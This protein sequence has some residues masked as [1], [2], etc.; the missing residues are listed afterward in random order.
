MKK[1][2]PIIRRTALSDGNFLTSLV[3]SSKPGAKKLEFPYDIPEIKVAPVISPE[4]KTVLYTTVSILATGMV[5]SAGMRY[6]K[7]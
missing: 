7:I 1:T 6:L 2:I 5:L 4:V 3:G